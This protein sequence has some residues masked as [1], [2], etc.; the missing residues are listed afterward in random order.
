MP[1]TLGDLAAPG[2]SALASPRAEGA[3]LVHWSGWGPSLLI[4]PPEQQLGVRFLLSRFLSMRSNQQLLQHVMAYSDYHQHRHD[5]RGHVAAIAHG[6]A[7]L[8]LQRVRMKD[9]RNCLVVDELS[10]ELQAFLHT[11]TPVARHLKEPRECGES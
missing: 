4:L 3:R 8:R 10:E 6:K 11:L 7:A 9:S 1:R 5:E 2:K